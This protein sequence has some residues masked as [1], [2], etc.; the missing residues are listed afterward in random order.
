MNRVLSRQ[1]VWG[2]AE[3]LPRSVSQHQGSIYSELSNS[4]DLPTCTLSKFIG[5]LFGST[6]LGDVAL[7]SM[8]LLVRIIMYSST[9]GV[10]LLFKYVI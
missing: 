8:N 3:M 10:M 4:Q 9:V 7:C 2:C 6:K 5:F 1:N